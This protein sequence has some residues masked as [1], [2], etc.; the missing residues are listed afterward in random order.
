MTVLRIRNVI[1]IDKNGSQQIHET[2]QLCNMEI[3]HAKANV[4]M[5]YDSVR[6]ISAIHWHSEG[7]KSAL[8]QR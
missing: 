4:E 2:L 1:R 8:P 5:M 6:G 7:F 3:F